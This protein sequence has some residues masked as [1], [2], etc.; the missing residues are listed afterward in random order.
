MP[1]VKVPGA[2]HQN[3]LAAKLSDILYGIV[4]LAEINFKHTFS[5]FDIKLKSYSLTSLLESDSC[6][7]PEAFRSRR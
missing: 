4:L 6:Q 7:L 2:G 3:F 1:R 5:F